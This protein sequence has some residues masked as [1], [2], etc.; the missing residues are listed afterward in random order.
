[1]SI[2]VWKRVLREQGG[3]TLPEMLVTMMVMIVVLFALYNIFDTSVRVFSFGNDKVEAVENARIGMEKMEREL[4]AAYP[5]NKP[6]GSTGDYRFWSPVSGSQEI[7]TACSQQITFG[8]DLNGNRV[9]DSSTE[10]ITY[11]LSTSGPPYR[12]QR[13]VGPSG[14]PQDVVEF[15]GDFA[16]PLPAGCTSARGLRFTPL[17]SSDGT[18]ASNAQIA[19][20]KIELLINKDGVRQTLTTD[21]AFRNPGD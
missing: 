4:R 2:G 8:N 21:V 12:L 1:M 6:A 14:T 19:K 16:P 10:Q 15:V 9:I 18:P 3:F 13:T 5:Y 17:T 20:V 11:Q 7:P